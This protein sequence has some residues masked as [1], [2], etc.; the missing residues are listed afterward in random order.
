MSRTRLPHAVGRAQ[1]VGRRA[2]AA[3][4][5]LRAVDRLDEEDGQQGDGER[6]RDGDEHQPSLEAEPRTAHRRQR[7]ERAVRR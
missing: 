1:R 5:L 6:Q 3:G 2:G 4:L 7:T